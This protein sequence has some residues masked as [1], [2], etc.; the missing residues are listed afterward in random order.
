MSF[1]K[2]AMTL[3]LILSTVAAV[4]QTKTVKGVI[5]EEETGSDGLRRG[6]HPRCD[7]RP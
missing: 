3:A 1:K 2:I 6:F 7:D 5:Y 4:A